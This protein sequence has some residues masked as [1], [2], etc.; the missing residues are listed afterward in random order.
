MNNLLNKGILAVC[1]NLFLSNGNLK[2]KCYGYVVDIHHVN[3]ITII[4]S[5]QLQILQC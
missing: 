2:T 3:L 4:R 1:Y 5:I